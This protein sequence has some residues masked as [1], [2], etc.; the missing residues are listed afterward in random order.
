MAKRRPKPNCT[1]ELQIIRR[2]GFVGLLV[3]AISD[4]DVEAQ[5][6]ALAVMGWVSRFTRGD[7]ADC[8]SCG[9]L[10]LRAEAVVLMMPTNQFDHQT[11]AGGLCSDC[12]TLPGE[13][14]TAG[15]MATIT[16]AMPSAKLCVMPVHGGR[17]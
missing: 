14:L 13:I 10:L 5:R 9:K 11:I 8:F 4:D 2:I 12:C 3:A 7:S 16:R 15:I 6:S 17:A 1:Y